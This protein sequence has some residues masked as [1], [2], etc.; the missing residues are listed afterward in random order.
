MT[1]AYNFTKL[2]TREKRLYSVNDL[3]ISSTGLPTKFLAILGGCI[4][5]SLLINIPICAI[6]GVWYINPLGD[7]TGDLNLTGPLIVLGI[8]IGLAAFLFY[9]KIQNYRVFDF[10]VVYFKPKPTININGQSVKDEQYLF[11]AFVERQ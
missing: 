7:G 3:T 11:D 5:I 2:N 8:P 10:L 4:A 9:C 1:T 6:T